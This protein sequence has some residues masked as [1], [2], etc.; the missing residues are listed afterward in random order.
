MELKDLVSKNRSYRRFDAA[1]PIASNTLEQ[2]VGLARFSPTGSNKQPLKFVLACTTEWNAKIFS[3]LA[4]AGF[5]TEWPGPSETER[6]TGYIVILV[7][8]SI[9]ESAP[10]D[11]GIAAQTILLGAV[12]K[13]LGGCMIGSV[14]QASLARM[15]ELP[16][17]L[18]IS[19]VVA[20]GKPVEN[21]VLEDA[22]QG[23]STKYYRDENQTH[24]VPKRKLDELVFKTLA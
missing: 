3:C 21:V 20:L 23:A 24:H 2:L 19:L 10:K 18:E 12:E 16:D 17:Q 11:V 7:D 8:K 13:G 6:P 9:N 4:W 5:L 14:K 15:L 22:E 1:V